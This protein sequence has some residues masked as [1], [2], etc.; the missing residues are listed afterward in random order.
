MQGEVCLY[1]DVDMDVPAYPMVGAT[2]KKTF[3]KAHEPLAG[4]AGR[5]SISF[6]P[7]RCSD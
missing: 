1:V 2:T 7:P 3:H 6:P 4:E 5:T